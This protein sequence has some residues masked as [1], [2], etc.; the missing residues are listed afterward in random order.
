VSN[1][2][3]TRDQIFIGCA[4]EDKDWLDRLLL[5][6]KPAKRLGTIETWTDR[7]IKPGQR[8]RPAIEQARDRTAVVVFL[9]SDHFLAS[10]F[11][12]EEEIGLCWVRLDYCAVEDS[13]LPE[14]QAVGDIRAPLKALDEAGLDKA[15][16]ELARAIKA[17]ATVRS[18]HRAPLAEE[19][20][21]TRGTAP[22]P[23]TEPPPA[24]APSHT[25]REIRTA[26]LSAIA[27]SLDLVPA[28]CAALAKIHLIV[29]DSGATADPGVLVLPASRLVA[30]IYDCLHTIE[31][32]A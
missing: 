12:D 7:D 5:K 17:A 30:E 15:L 3:S 19:P 32:L 21:P 1:S 26:A 20:G 14:R 13:P 28:L 27:E 16:Y 6:L 29:I 11:I 4:R 22:P 25:A 18:S 31:A 9:V 23:A 2:Q 24:A 10:D 8:W